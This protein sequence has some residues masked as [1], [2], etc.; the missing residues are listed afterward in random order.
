MTPK[1]TKITAADLVSRHKSSA[2]QE[3]YDRALKHAYRDQ[4]ALLR[5]AQA[6][7]SSKNT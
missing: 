6:L 3:V 2:V 1:Q 4:Q 7:K 5:K